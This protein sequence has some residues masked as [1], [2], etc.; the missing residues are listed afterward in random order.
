MHL[1]MWTYARPSSWH[2]VQAKRADR[3][4]SPDASQYDGL[5][6]LGAPDCHEARRGAWACGAGVDR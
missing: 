5:P 4:G 1:H 6:R 3:R 2:L